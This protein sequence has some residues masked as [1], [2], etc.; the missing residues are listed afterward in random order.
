MSDEF[1]RWVGSL[2]DAIGLREWEITILRG[3]LRDDVIARCNV[4]RARQAAEITLGDEFFKET[5]EGKRATIVHELLHCLFAPIG[6]I[7]DESLPALLGRPAYN[8][9]ETAHD[10]ATERCLDAIAVSWARL[11]PLPPEGE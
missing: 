6:E 4:P 9:F 10:L 7:V 3:E 1:N 5:P 8:T 2:A 11:L